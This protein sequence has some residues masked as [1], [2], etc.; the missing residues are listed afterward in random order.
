MQLIPIQVQNPKDKNFNIKRNIS[1]KNINTE[2]D[3]DIVDFRNKNVF[4][5]GTHI[6]GAFKGKD[7]HLT[8]RHGWFNEQITGSFL[9]K[10]VELEYKRRFF[11]K[12]SISGTVEDK[13]VNL[14]ISYGWLGGKNISGDFEGEQVDLQITP[15]WFSKNIT[16]IFQGQNVDLALK[17]KFLAGKSL[18]GKIGDKDL[19]LTIDHEL[20]RGDHVTGT[21]PN[22]EKGNFLPVLFYIL[23]KKDEEDEAARE[24]QRHNS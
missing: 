23:N 5:D 10:D 17:Y 11:S 20:F 2:T 4:F 22:L 15:G 8:R 16:G 7:I 19:N 3:C 13:D 21:C 6:D 18:E 9:G 12:D 1:F 24:A 14:E